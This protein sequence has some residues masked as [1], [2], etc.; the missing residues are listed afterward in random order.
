MINIFYF[1]DSGIQNNLNQV[2]NILRDFNEKKSTGNRR[3]WFFG[4]SSL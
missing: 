1:A 4:I 3:S 2:Y